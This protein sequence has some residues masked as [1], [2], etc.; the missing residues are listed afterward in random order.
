MSKGER[1]EERKRDERVT[2]NV[3]NSFGLSDVDLLCFFMLKY[4]LVLVTNTADSTV[5]R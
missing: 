2:F 3:S 5:G 4:S 1:E